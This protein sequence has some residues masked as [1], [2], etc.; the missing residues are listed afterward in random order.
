MVIRRRL[1]LNSSR[2]YA[3]TLYVIIEGAC[4]LDAVYEL[5][6]LYDETSSAP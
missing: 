1:K 6:Y 4:I 2:L 5:Y 3:S